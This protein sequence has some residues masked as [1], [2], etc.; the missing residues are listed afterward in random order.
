[1]EGIITDQEATKCLDYIRDNAVKYA[2]AKA[3]RIYIE[4]FRKSKKAILMQEAMKS[5]SGKSTVQER[6]SYAYAHDDY[7]ELLDGLKTAVEDEEKLKW[8]LVAAQAKLETYR[9]I[10]ANNRRAVQ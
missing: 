7:V 10:S 2:Q 5:I 9:T 4:Q 6:E 3:N 1:M 8:L